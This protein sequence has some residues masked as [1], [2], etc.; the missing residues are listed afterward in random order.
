MPDE[1]FKIRVPLVAAPL[2][3][4]QQL[5]S[6]ETDEKQDETTHRHI[7]SGRKRTHGNNDNCIHQ[8]AQS[9]TFNICLSILGNLEQKRI[10][11]SSRFHPRVYQRMSLRVKSN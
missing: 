4:K 10:H 5:Q 9:I 11:F 1:C 2:V 8:I 7:S 3:R 6:Q